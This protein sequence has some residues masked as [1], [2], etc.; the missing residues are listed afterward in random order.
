MKS[1]WSFIASAKSVKAVIAVLAM[2]TGPALAAAAELPWEIRAP[3]KTAIIKYKLTGPNTEDVSGKGDSTLYIRDHGRERVMINNYSM[4]G[5]EGGWFPMDSLT[6]IT[7]QEVIHIRTEPDDQG[8]SHRIA[9]KWSNPIKFYRASYGTLKGEDLENYHK[10]LRENGTLMDF[11]GMLYNPEQRKAKK[12]LGY[13][14]DMVN[15]LGNQMYYMQGA[16]IPLEGATF[17][18]N[19]HVTGIQKNASIPDKVFQ[20]PSGIKIAFDP[21]TE[22]G[23]RQYAEMNIK[24]LG[25]MMSGIK[26]LEGLLKKREKTK[27]AESQE[28]EVRTVETTKKSPKKKRKEKKEEDDLEKS[29]KKGLKSLKN[30]FG[31]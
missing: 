23:N 21:D 27:S 20:P 11:M 1:K 22:D 25:S 8:K 3:F 31:N 14:T 12:I 24:G 13:Q 15:L 16:P 26:G 4:K 10:S 18:M 9:K 5:Q 19:F 28:K 30:L 29:L 17:M 2:L 6:I 7:S